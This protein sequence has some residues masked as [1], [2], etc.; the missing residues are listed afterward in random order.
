M[1]LQSQTD[2][3]WMMAKWHNSYGFGRNGR[4]E[5]LVYGSD[6]ILAAIEDL[7][8]DTSAKQDD[9]KTKLH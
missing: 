9:E 2:N 3:S 7:K 4:I 5:G 6:G 8:N 1:K